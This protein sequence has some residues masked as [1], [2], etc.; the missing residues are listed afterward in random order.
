MPRFSASARTAALPTSVRGPSIYNIASAANPRIREIGIFNTTTTAFAVSLNRMTARGTVGA[1]ITAAKHDPGGPAA[2]ATPYQTH[3]ADATASD[4]VVRA[5]G[6]AAIGAG[7]VWTFGGDSGIQL[8][9]GSTSNGLAL[10]LPTGTAQ[11]FDFY[12]IWDE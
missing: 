6:G 1:A 10:L 11:H 5:S 9:D 4:E 2:D 7:I 12:W 8:A 3:T